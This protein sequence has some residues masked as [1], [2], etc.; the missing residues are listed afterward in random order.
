MLNVA[1]ETKQEEQKPMEKIEKIEK[2]VKRRISVEKFM[3]WL[4]GENRKEYV[5]NIS[6]S[7]IL[8]SAFLVFIGLLIGSFIG[9]FIAFAMLG[10]FLFIIGVLVLIY[11]NF[12]RR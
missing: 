5:E 7:I 12:I 10:S 9:P 1:E 8:F 2:E 4:K 3:K 6:Y 11:S